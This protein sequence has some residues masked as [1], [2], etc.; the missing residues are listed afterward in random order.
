MC[1]AKNSDHSR[2]PKNGNKSIQVYSAVGAL[3]LLF[4]NS[5]YISELLSLNNCFGFLLICILISD[6]L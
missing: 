4:T 2:F 1:Q 5:Q 3:T 6:N